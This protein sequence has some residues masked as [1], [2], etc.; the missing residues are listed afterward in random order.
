MNSHN[1]PLKFWQNSLLQ[2]PANKRSAFLQEVYF[3]NLYRARIFAIALLLFHIALLAVDFSHEKQGLWTTM[4]GYIYLFYMHVILI[5]GLSIFILLFYGTRRQS[6]EQVKKSDMAILLLFAVF[7]MLWS[8]GLSSVDQLIHNQITVYLIAI[9]AVAASFYISGT[10][11]V[12]IYV[13]AHIGFLIGIGTT[14][15]NPNIALGH[16]ING[17]ALVVIAWVLSRMV[18]A[19]RVREFLHTSTIEQQRL[20]IESSKNKVESIL[21]NILPESI[22]RTINGS[23]YP[24]PEYNDSTTI[25]FAD[26]VSFHKIAERSD[27]REVVSILER[28]FGLFDETIREYSLEKLKTIGD[29]YM[30]AGGLFTDNSQTVEAV[31]AALDIVEKTELISAEL[32]AS[33]GNE[34]SV[35]IGIHTGPAITGI[36]GRWRFIYDVWGPTVNI[37]SRLESASLPNRVNISK[38]VYELIAPLNKYSFEPRGSLSIK[39]MEPV[40]MFFVNRL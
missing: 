28:M 25:V 39:N 21:K 40:E 11:S 4:P 2:I 26:F 38:Q 14:Q 5:A 33:T 8:A 15:S 23:G 27:A 17:T 6:P 22:V 18:F 10:Y 7:M 35:R 29:C 19:A 1:F 36:I 31:E 12:L 24:P 16:Y 30:F 32:K 20:Q 34:W 37:A 3:T 9:F 13:V